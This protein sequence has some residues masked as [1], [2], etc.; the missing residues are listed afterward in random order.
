M[1]VRLS[2]ALLAT[3]GCGP[4]HS[5]G[6][7]VAS[8]E[9]P[10]RV[11]DATFPEVLRAFRSVPFDHPD[12]EHVRERLV[13][14]LETQTEEI[15]G[16]ANF[17]RVVEHFA[18]LTSLLSPEDFAEAR[19]PRELERTARFLS[20][21][22]SSRGD[23]G[24][25]LSGLR[26]LT[27]I[28]PDQPPLVAQYA[29]LVLWGQEA[30][31]H[32]PT[33]ERYTRLIDVWEEHARLT[34]A[35]EVLSKLADLYAERR[36]ALMRRGQ[37]GPQLGPEEA[38]A[39]LQLAPMIMARTPLDIAAVYLRNGDLASAL[40]RIEA[41]GAGRGTEMRL[42]RALREAQQ[43]GAAGDDAL[44]DIAE[45][46]REPRPDVTQGLCELGHRRDPVDAR[47]PV[48]LARVA[49]DEE[50]YPDATAWYA[51]A[52]RLA[53][54]ERVLYDEALEKL[55]ELISQGV[56]ESNPSAARGVARQAEIILGERVSRW[57][58]S[59]PAVPPERLQYV[60]A[61]LEMNSGNAAEARTR[62]HASIAARETIDAL[63]QLGQLEERTGQPQEAVRLYRRALDLGPA[64]AD[65][66]LTTALVLEHLGDAFRRNADVAQASRMY[67][68][69]LQIWERLTATSGQQQAGP[70]EALG[71][72]HIRTGVM[73]DRL[74]RRTEAFTSFRAAMAADPSSRE[75]YAT[76][77]AYLVVAQP[78]LAFS[79]EVFFL[80]LRHLRLDPEWKVYFAL[81]VSAI[82]A[83]S[84]GQLDADV[85]AVLRELRGSD[86][87]FGRLARFG[88]GDIPYSEL[89]ADAST[90]GQRAEADFY[91]GTRLL[92]AGQASDAMAAFERV[93]ATRMVNFYEYA[94]AQ[95]LLGSRP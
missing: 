39:Q 59:P 53:P 5:G 2:L 3:S 10:D 11:T 85:V 24:R 52:I 15:L 92:A 81:W 70:S 20:E 75:T 16:A 74:D 38:F 21:H 44:L 54:T 43:E 80:A 91:Q 34:P 6:T 87:W 40:M 28:H 46:Y 90:R 48:C 95:D 18:R 9:I 17:D 89:L 72:A 66:E 27:A 88:T 12:R 31:A 55:D 71:L 36:D 35:P 56:F 77:L 73:L 51:E 37:D 69:A 7:T 60:V 83:R 32:L 8:V 86:A 76:I 13:A 65:G 61:L 33:L 30:R 94:M 84:N 78:D 14:Y 25:V 49:V 63:L 41:L 23:E 64:T 1:L 93:L 19:I 26:V 42:A 50:D 58:D 29:A 4:S 67:R 57:P 22:G 79:H 47:F 68:Q 82:A 62:L 45:A